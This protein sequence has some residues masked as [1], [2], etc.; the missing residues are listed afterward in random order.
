ME[1]RVKFVGAG[2]VSST[3]K[4]LLLLD[5]TCYIRPSY[6][7][8]SCTMATAIVKQSSAMELDKENAAP[9]QGLSDAQ[10]RDMYVNCLK[11]ASEGKITSKN[12]WQLKLIDHLDDLVKPIETDGGLVCR[13][14]SRACTHTSCHRHIG[15][16]SAGEL[17]H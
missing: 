9:M 13:R 5:F 7:H 12:T 17:Y 15:Q 4:L 3:S 8:R 2:V 10:I 1:R 11:L 6:A 16:F 14:A